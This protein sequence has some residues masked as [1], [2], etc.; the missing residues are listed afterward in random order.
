[1]DITTILGFTVCVCVCARMRACVCVE[2]SFPM[3]HHIGIK[4]F[5]VFPERM[6]GLAL[7]QGV[8]YVESRACAA[9]SRL[10]HDQ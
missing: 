9:Y 6:G 2:M 5:L 7:F 4:Y 8:S 1:M 10:L 3:V